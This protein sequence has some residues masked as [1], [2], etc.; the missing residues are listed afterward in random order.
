MGKDNLLEIYLEEMKNEHSSSSRSSVTRIIER[1]VKTLSI[2]QQ[3]VDRERWLKEAKESDSGGYY[4]TAR[5]IIYF[6]SNLGI[7]EVDR[8]RIWLSDAETAEKEGYFICAR[9]L[10]ARLLSTFPGRD[11]LWLRA[12]QFEKDH[13]TFTIVDELLRR[14]VAYCPRAEKLW[15]LAA[16]E[17]WRHHDADGARAVLHEAFSSNPGSE[18]IWLEAVALE[19]QAGELDR[20]RIL[21]SRARNSEAD[22]GR[23][24]YKS[25][26]LERE[27]GCAE[28]E[29]ELLEQGLSKHPEEPKLWLMLGQW[30]QRQEP[31]QIE[32]ARA[33]FSSGLQHCPTSV[34]LWLSL[35]YLEEKANKWT[36]ARAIL[37]KARQKLPKVDVLWEESVWLEERIAKSQRPLST[38]NQL[39]SKT[40]SKSALSVLAKALQECPDSGRL[41]AVAIELEPAKQRRARSVDALTR[42]DR[43]PYVMVAVARL[44][45]GENKIEKARSW[46]QRAVALDPELGDAWAAWYAFERRE[47]GESE[48]REIE[49]KVESHPPRKGSKWCTVRK[50]LENVHLTTLQVLEKVA[51][52]FGPFSSQ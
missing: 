35:A 47:N 18:T 40:T 17:K 10:F 39:L 3:I 52:E 44:F 15:L 29:K 34:P 48:I 26:L 32:E 36:R 33:A 27:A 23:V 1:A 31:P 25:A 24:Y 4:R 12:A 43:D 19:K 16:N 20:A 51:Q 38:D 8:E 46:F 6:S 50:A 14:A 22:S 28:A 13:G 45:W 49:S 9:A 42:C 41:W 30:H 21:A 11:N 2:K 37:E 7:E 5:D